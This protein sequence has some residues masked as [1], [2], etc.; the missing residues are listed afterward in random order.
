MIQSVGVPFMGTLNPK[1]KSNHPPIIT[2]Q[3]IRA[4]TRDC[5]YAVPSTKIQ[6]LNPIQLKI[7]IQSVGVP[8]M[9]TLKPKPKPI[10]PTIITIQTIR[11][12]TRDCPYAVLSTIKNILFPHQWIVLNIL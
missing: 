2:I 9:G 1:P 3:T 6:R 5:P 10:H 4:T 12:T 7:M 8:F 11:A